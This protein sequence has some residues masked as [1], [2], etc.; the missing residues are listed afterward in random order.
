M[1]TVCTMKFHAEFDLLSQTSTQLLNILFMTEGWSTLNGFSRI[2]ALYLCEGGVSSRG[3]GLCVPRDEE[4][5]TKCS[6][7]FNFFPFPYMNRKKTTSTKGARILAVGSTIY[8]NKQL[9]SLLTRRWCIK[10]WTCQA[11]WWI[12]SMT[13]RVSFYIWRPSTKIFRT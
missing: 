2:L 8:D 5:A 6:S 1:P 4:N 12:Y 11:I 3:Y 13:S 10:K 7:F 9:M